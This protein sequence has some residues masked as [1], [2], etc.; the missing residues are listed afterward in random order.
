VPK[1]DRDYGGD[2]DHLA[3]VSEW[4]VAEASEEGDDHE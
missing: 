1:S 2:Y 3:R 4:S